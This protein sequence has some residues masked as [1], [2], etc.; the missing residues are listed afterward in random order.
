[1]RGRSSVRGNRFVIVLPLVGTVFLLAMLV[2]PA[3]DSYLQPLTF[4]AFTVALAALC[5]IVHAGRGHPRRKALIV[6]VAMTVAMTTAVI[7][8]QTP[9][10][11]AFLAWY[12]WAGGYAGMVSRRPGPVAA[13]TG[14]ICLTLVGALYVRGD[15]NDLALTSAAVLLSVIASAM[16]TF[17]FFRW[18]RG[19]AFADPLT[20]LTN[21]AGLMHAGEPAI[22]EALVSGRGLAVM[23]LDISRFR[24][25]NSALGHQAGDEALREYADLLRQVHP[26]PAFVGR[27]GGDEFVLVLPGEDQDAERTDPHG[28][29]L[30]RLGEKILDQL[31]G[32]VHI[33]GIDIEMESTAGV[34]GAPRDGDR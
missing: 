15:L 6:T 1:M 24:E 17:G 23:V 2:L 33:R 11:L 19:Q 34:A 28:Q 8:D 14:A 22:T 7:G 25:I 18:G 32:P 12:P 21:R 29:W 27:L 13:L 30:A 20:G 4:A 5:Y 9:T 31:D 3:S 16:F 10:S 26:R